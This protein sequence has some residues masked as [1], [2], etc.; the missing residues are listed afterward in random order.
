M[1]AR[2]RIIIIL[3]VVIIA[4]PLVSCQSTCS[5]SSVTSNPAANARSYSSMHS[6][7]PNHAKSW[8]GSASAWVAQSTTVNREWMQMDLDNVT[9]VAQIVT[10]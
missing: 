7:H 2:M 5:P 3:V 1:A 8:L 6:N 4:S 9:A 10:Q